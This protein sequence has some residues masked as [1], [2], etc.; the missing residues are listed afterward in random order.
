MIIDNEPPN[1]RRPQ[2]GYSG[3][4]I[5]LIIGLGIFLGESLSDLRRY[6]WLRIEL[7]QAA[8]EA[9]QFN[10]QMRERNKQA[11]E[12]AKIEETRRMQEMRERNRQEALEA[13]QRRQL[14]EQRRQRDELAREQRERDNAQRQ[15]A[16][17]QARETCDYW[18]QQYNAKPRD[19]QNIAMKNAACNRLNELQLGR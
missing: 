15:A 14:E 6:V 4:Q 9:E 8:I 2:R 17:K 19:T 18:Q 7:H 3:W 5:V 1:R 13:E 11:Q 16:I 10:A 12:Q